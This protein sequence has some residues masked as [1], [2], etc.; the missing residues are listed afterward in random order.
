MQTTTNLKKIAIA[1]GKGGTGKTTVAT[2]LTYIAAQLG[3][4]VTLLDCDVEEPNAH[5]FLKPQIKET[6]PV[7]RTVP[8]VAEDTCTSCGKCGEI[9]QFSAIVLMGKKVIT[10]PEL[11]HA[12]GGCSLVCKSKAISET[13]YEVGKIERGSFDSIGVIKGVL[14]VGEAMSPPVI[15]AV[16][17]AAPKQGLIIIDAPPGTS[18]PVVESIRGVDYV[19]LVTEPTPFGLHDLQLAVEMVRAMSLP[20]GI[21]IN[22]ADSGYD[23]VRNYCLENK[24]SILRGIPDDRQ[25]AEAY[26]KGEMICEALPKYQQLYKVLY[27]ELLKK[28]S[29]NA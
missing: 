23:E 25:I 26:S 2:N 10:Y 21:V 20:F 22:R 27:Q 14:N 3:D 19:V 28:V 11:C 6:H 18:C 13:S 15:R 1:S 24:I 9:C 17:Q 29:E 12:C 8:V 5:I 4:Q 16:R 7:F